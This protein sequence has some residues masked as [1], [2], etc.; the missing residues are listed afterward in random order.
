MHCQ[1]FVVT[2]CIY[3]QKRLNSTQKESYMCQQDDNSNNNNIADGNKAEP[4]RGVEN[5]CEM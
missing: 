1:F 3:K 5:C 2:V 4:G